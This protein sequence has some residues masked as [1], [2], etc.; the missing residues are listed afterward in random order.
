MRW[1]IDGGTAV[2]RRCW[3]PTRSCGFNC[4]RGLNREAT[5][6]EQEFECFD[7]S[8][9][10]VAGATDTTSQGTYLSACNGNMSAAAGTDSTPDGMPPHLV[11][12]VGLV[13]LV[14]VLPDENN[15]IGESQLLP[16]L[17]QFS[18]G[19]F[20]SSRQSRGGDPMP[21]RLLIRTGWN[22]ELPHPCIAPETIDWLKKQFNIILLGIDAPSI[23]PDG[24]S[25]ALDALHKYAI[26]GLFNLNFASNWA[27]LESRRFTDEL[28]LYAPPVIRSSLGTASTRAVLLRKP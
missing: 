27:G 2:K 6:R 7:I 22:G 15:R 1:P 25:H 8:R 23:D 16:E 28:M 24:Q 17:Q 18:T 9:A 11:P 20:S 10:P 21:E 4:I 14:N 13:L 19:L 12:F 3:T 5:L 26:H